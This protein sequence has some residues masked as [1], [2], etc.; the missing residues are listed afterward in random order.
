MVDL[1]GPDLLPESE[2][3]PALPD[4]VSY[5]DFERVFLA[6]DALLEVGLPVQSAE[7]TARLGKLPDAGEESS[8]GVEETL[9]AVIAEQ[10]RQGVVLAEILT[11]LS[12]IET[13]L[14]QRSS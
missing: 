7:I 3:A 13:E 12:K 10:R 11:R 6:V 4:L 8:A 14:S 1:F 9:D 5:P 2:I